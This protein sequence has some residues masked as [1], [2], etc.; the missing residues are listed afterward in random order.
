M[1]TLGEP[2]GVIAN[3]LLSR[4]SFG[5]YQSYYTVLFPTHTASDISW[6]GSV[7]LALFFSLAVVAGPLFD[8]GYFQWLIRVGSA[9]Y[10]TS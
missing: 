1:R 4:I 6:I 3:R 5:V 2:V 10:L 9:I 8:K 7:Q